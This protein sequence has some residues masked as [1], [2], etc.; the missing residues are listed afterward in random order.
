MKKYH[1]LAIGLL[2]ITIVL[3][4]GTMSKTSTTYATTGMSD[5]TTRPRKEDCNPQPDRVGNDGGGDG[6]DADRDG[7]GGDD[8]PHQTDDD[9]TGEQN[10]WGKVTSIL[11]QN[12]DGKPRNR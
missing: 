4:V 10:C 1:I 6:T 9:D 3:A 8:G 5:C 11:T 12:D 2:A 7:P